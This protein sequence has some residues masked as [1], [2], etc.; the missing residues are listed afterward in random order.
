MLL[1]A[2]VVVK[3]FVDDAQ[4][5]DGVDQ[6]EVPGDLEVGSED[7]R[8]AVADG[9]HGDELG[10]VFESGQKEDHTEQKERWS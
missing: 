1:K 8:D 9:E 7:E 3:A 5:D 6:I 10:H 4:G 2:A